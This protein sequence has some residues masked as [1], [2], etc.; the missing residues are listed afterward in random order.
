MAIILGG[1]GL[2]V[3]HAFV[4]RTDDVADLCHRFVG[5]G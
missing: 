3:L 5:Y 2:W 4:E 1:I